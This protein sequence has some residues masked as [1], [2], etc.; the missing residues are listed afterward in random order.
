MSLVET[1]PYLVGRLGRELLYVS[2]ASS[3]AVE[4]V[5][6]SALTREE[7]LIK[8]LLEEINDEKS[9]GWERAFI[10]SV[11]EQVEQGKKLTEKQRGKLEQ[12]WRK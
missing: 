10:E 3:N 1:N 6:M 9:S 12:I 7:Y 4:G 11:A 5:K 8:C 2:V